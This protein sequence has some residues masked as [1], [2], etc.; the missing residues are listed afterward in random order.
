MLEPS[1]GDLGPVDTN[2]PAF[3]ART[4][5]PSRRQQTMLRRILDRA[6]DFTIS[7]QSVRSLVLHRVRKPLSLTRL[8]QRDKGGER[9]G[10]STMLLSC[11]SG[12]PV[13]PESSPLPVETMMR[14]SVVGPWFVGES[15]LGPW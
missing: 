14:G 5:Q 8:L 11:M 6:A 2:E 9:Q 15:S 4:A 1:L 10:P 7:V 13:F 12:A 3:S